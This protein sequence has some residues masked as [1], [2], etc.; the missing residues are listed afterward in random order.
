MVRRLSWHG[1][2]IAFYG[3]FS[4]DNQRE[5]SN[6]DQLRGAERTAEAREGR[7]DPELIF[8]DSATSGATL[9]RP[10][11]QRLMRAVDEGRIDIVLTEDISRISRNQADVATVLQ[12]MQHRS[13]SLIGIA[14]SIDCGAEDSS[15]LLAIKAMS[16]GLYLDDLKYRIRRALKGRAVAKEVRS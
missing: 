10:E 2:R 11:F 15:M 9:Q 12:R 6:E 3:R 14:G 4:S 16:R 7:I 1:L 5:S 8:M 13:V